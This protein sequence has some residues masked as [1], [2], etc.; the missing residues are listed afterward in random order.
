MK[1]LHFN[2]ELIEK[3]IISK[4]IGKDVCKN[5]LVSVVIP[6]YN[7]ADFIT[8]TLDSALSQTFQDFEIVV[9]NDGSPDSKNLE[10][11]LEPYF[12]QIV[13]IKQTNGGAAAARNTAIHVAKGE[14]IAFLDGDDIWLPNKLEI[15]IKFLQEKNLDMTYCDALMFGEKLWDGKTFMEKNISVGQVTPQSL[16]STDCNVI[17]SGTICRRDKIVKLNGFDESQEQF[18][19][20]DFDLW[21]RL[22]KNDYKIDYQKEVLLKHRVVIGSLSG[23][24]IERAERDLKALNAI[25]EKNELSIPEHKIWS[26]KIE[27]SEAF[28]ELEKSKLCMIKKDFA[29]SKL[30]LKN[31]NKYFKKA[32]YSIIIWLLRIQPNLAL[33]LFQ[34]KKSDEYSFI[35]AS[36]KVIE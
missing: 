19:F 15:Q 32:K 17:T 9:V 12:S 36:N 13:Y 24:S 8:E 25:K 3:R 20:E 28:L 26:A 21:F 29:K 23:G 33:K 10:E 31:A 18:G 6:A 2:P 11:V 16:I 35:S 1:H 27:E 7:V 34:A 22:A 5:P 14:F 4:S 30:H